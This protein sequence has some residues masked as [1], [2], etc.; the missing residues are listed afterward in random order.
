MLFEVYFH[1]FLLAKKNYENKRINKKILIKKQDDLIKLLSKDLDL[2]LNDLEFTLKNI[3]NIK[4]TKEF[5]E[6]IIKLTSKEKEKRENESL[7]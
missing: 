6:S 3:K 7:F 4:N 5:S 2:T 1:N